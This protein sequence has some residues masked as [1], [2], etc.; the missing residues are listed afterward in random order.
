MAIFNG[1]M[2]I[3]NQK[4]IID[5]HIDACNTASGIN[6]RGDWQYVPFACEYPAAS[7]WHINYKE[8]LSVLFAARR[9]GHLWKNTR[10]VVFTDNQVAKATLNRGTS[11]HQTVMQVLR[12][13]FW[14]SVWHNFDL[15]AEYLPGKDND[16]AHA[17]SRLAEPGQLVRLDSLLG[18]SLHPGLLS[19][20]VSYYA[21]LAISPQI[22]KW[23]QLKQSWT[24]KSQHTGEPPSPS[25]SARPTRHTCRRTCSSAWTW[26][27]PRFP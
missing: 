16:M 6:F 2:P 1:T 11:R 5:V 7:S 22:H 20:H 12:E 18:H 3:R 23:Q 19:S 4:P 14:L 21:L 13:L 25:P 17:I 15:T 10:V 8:L 24:V 9:W 26:A 27:T